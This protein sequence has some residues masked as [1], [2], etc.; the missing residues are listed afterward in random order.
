MT[1]STTFHALA[2]RSLSL[3]VLA[4]IMLPVGCS[5]PSRQPSATRTAMG[6]TASTPDGEEADDADDDAEEVEIALSDVPDVVRK[7]AEAAVPGI[8]LEEAAGATHYYYSSESSLQPKLTV[9]YT[10]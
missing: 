6:M 10:N 3:M 8:V 2:L 5:Q 4:S 1:T 9:C 7:A